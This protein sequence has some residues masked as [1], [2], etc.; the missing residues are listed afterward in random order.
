MCVC[1]VL[2]TTFIHERRRLGI[3]N[4]YMSLY[5]DRKKDTKTNEKQTDKRR[6]E[7]Y[8]MF[9]IMCDITI[10]GMPYKF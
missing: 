5:I 10:I 7:R 4:R 9:T 1:V 6:E 2:Q 3:M 8:M